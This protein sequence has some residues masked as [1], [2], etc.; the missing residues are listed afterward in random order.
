MNVGQ[1]KAISVED[2]YRLRTEVLG[3]NKVPAQ[4]PEDVD[5][6]SFH[7]GT[8]QQNKL[9]GVA[10]F[11]R[12][13]QKGEPSSQRIWRLRGMAIDPRYQGKNLG[14]EL[15]CFGMHQL[16]QKACTLLWCNARTPAVNFYKKHNFTVEGEE[17]EIPR[18]GPHFRMQKV[19]AQ[20]INNLS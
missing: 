1:I 18:A 5:F 15:L 10:S 8:Y 2:T 6:E 20:S 7:L 3:L 13:D 16:A 17:F 14:T 11:Y 4:F 12:Q 9:V 19:C